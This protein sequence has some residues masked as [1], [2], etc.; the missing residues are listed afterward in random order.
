[1]TNFLYPKRKLIFI[2][3]HKT[4]GSSIRKALGRKMDRAGGVIP[5]NWPAYRRFAVVRDPVSRFISTMNMFRFGREDFDDFFANG[6]F[7]ELTAQQ[8]LDILEDPIVPFDR[9]VRDPISTLKHHLL[10]QTH[11]Y[12]CLQHAHE[13]LRF[14]NLETDFAAFCASQG[15][16]IAL[17]RLGASRKPDGALREADLTSEDLGRIWKC[18][19][20]DFVQLGYPAPLGFGDFDAN[21]PSEGPD[22]WPLLRFHLTGKAI[23][24]QDRLPDPECDLQ[25][26]MTARVMAKPGDSWAGRKADLTEHFLHL[27]PE[28]HG[29]PR[30][31]HLLACVIVALRRD[32]TDAAGRRLFGRIVRE[33][34]QELP[35]HLNLRWLT[36][37]CD[38]F[39]DV[40]DDPVD[41]ATAMAGALLA[42]TIKLSETER[43]LFHPPQPDTPLYRFSRGGVL[44]DGVITFWVGKGDMVTNLLSRAAATLENA[45]AA[46]PFTGEIIARVLEERTVWQRMMKL[47]GEA[48]PAM[49]RSELIDSLRKQL[50]ERED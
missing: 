29:R 33:F 43:L 14:E 28:F 5:A 23:S 27:E 3:I 38:T 40:A 34:G 13:V 41:R 50:S 2:H 36:S 17:K 24:A 46:A 16:Q 45:G 19:H 39:M 18:Y 21:E 20:Q 44:F 1:M 15:V 25:P 11:P 9:R 26:F 10:P 30:L 31:A 8:A 49:A 4:A 48:G 42:N 32:P 22:P 35:A 47:Q 7:P 37:V 6:H 12:N